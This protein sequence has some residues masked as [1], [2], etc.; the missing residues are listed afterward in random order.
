[1]GPLGEDAIAACIAHL[2]SE[3]SPLIDRALLFHGK[4][5]HNGVTAEGK[6][7]FRKSAVKSQCSDPN[8]KKRDARR[9]CGAEE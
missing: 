9:H 1:M 8:I 4:P 6:E 5:E 3:N 7:V 2:P